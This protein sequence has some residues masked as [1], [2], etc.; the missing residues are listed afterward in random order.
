MARAGNIHS[1]APTQMAETRPF[2]RLLLTL[3]TSSWQPPIG[4]GRRLT[5]HLGNLE[6]SGWT[7]RQ[8]LLRN[9]LLWRHGRQQASGQ[10]ILVLPQFAER[11]PRGPVA[12]L[13][14]ADLMVA[15]RRATRQ[16][17]RAGLI[18]RQRALALAE[19]GLEPAE[20]A[21]LAEAHLVTAVA[22]NWLL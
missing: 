10:P 3:T 7:L 11:A 8:A 12:V 22:R 21:E 17:L 14:L 5:D 1:A 18:E 9:Y 15:E 20:V 4:L 2:A 16:P 13:V 19:A 6:L